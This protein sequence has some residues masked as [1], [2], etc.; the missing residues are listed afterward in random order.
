MTT[1]APRLG[2]LS[3]AAPATSRVQADFLTR[4]AD[5]IAPWSGPDYDGAS[6]AWTPLLLAHRLIHLRCEQGTVARLAR[7]ITR[8]LAACKYDHPRWNIERAIYREEDHLL[9]LR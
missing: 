4:I 1:T 3:S 2:A 7:D 5:A 8:A 6:Y 9:W